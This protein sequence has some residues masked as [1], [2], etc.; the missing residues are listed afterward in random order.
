MFHRRRC[1]TSQVFPLPMWKGG[2]FFR[3]FGWKRF[4]QRGS[5]IW[6]EIL[7]HQ[8]GWW[9]ARYFAIHFT[10]QPSV[11]THFCWMVFWNPASKTTGW[12]FWNH[13]NNGIL[14]FYHINRLAHFSHQQYHSVF[15]CLAFHCSWS[16]SLGASVATKRLTYRGH[17]SR[18][19]W[20]IEVSPKDD[21]NWRNGRIQSLLKLNGYL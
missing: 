5:H 12:M 16:T 7:G 18:P 11:A 10:G 13:V 1:P 6:I 9:L 2:D 14:I 17:D 8:K 20:P 21:P 15:F 19:T 4:N 3:A